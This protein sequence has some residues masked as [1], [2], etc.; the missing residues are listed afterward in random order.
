MIEHRLWFLFDNG[1]N[2]LHLSGKKFHMWFTVRVCKCVYLRVCAAFPVKCL[3]N[4]KPEERRKKYCIPIFTVMA[5]NGVV[6]DFTTQTYRNMHTQ[7]MHRHTH[8]HTLAHSLARTHA[9]THLCK[10]WSGGKMTCLLKKTFRC[11]R[12]IKH[13]H[14][15][16]L[17]YSDSHTRYLWVTRFG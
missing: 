11:F 14:T 15:I 5:Y 16:Y 7:S 17:L 13:F 8:T 1:K 9:Y 12:F 6:H 3:L 10:Q 4:E 2:D